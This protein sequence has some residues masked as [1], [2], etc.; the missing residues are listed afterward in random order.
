M[1]HVCAGADAGVASLGE[2]DD[3]VGIPD[4]VVCVVWPLWVV[5]IAHLDIELFHELFDGVDCVGGFGVNHA[6]SEFFG[7][8]KYLAAFCFVLVEL[9]DS[10]SDR[11][12][13]VFFED[14][15]DGGKSFG[16]NA[17]SCFL[18]G[19]GGGNDLAWEKFGRFQARRCGL[20]AG[21]FE[22][23]LPEGVGLGSKSEPVSPDFSGNRRCRD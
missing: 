7:E 12:D 22:G 9:N 18:I 6:D 21:L 11:S 1:P 19:E 13:V 5:V 2:F 10:D 17:G 15:F 14:G 16:G 23:E 20:L 4:F 3:V 8:L